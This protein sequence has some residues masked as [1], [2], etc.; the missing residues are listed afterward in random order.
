MSERSD[1]PLPAPVARAAADDPAAPAAPAAARKRLRTKTAEAG[2][3]A[4]AA[5]S[6]PAEADTS[7]EAA[8]PRAGEAAPRGRGMHARPPPRAG[9]IWAMHAVTGE[10]KWFPK[11]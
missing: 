2:T 7:A 10:W 4:E 3:A 9:G 5:D 1:I 8:A 6:A 11:E